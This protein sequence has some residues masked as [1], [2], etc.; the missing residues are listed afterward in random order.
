MNVLLFLRE[1][2]YLS[3]KLLKSFKIKKYII[4]KNPNFLNRIKYTFQALKIL[5]NINTIRDLLNFKK[6]KIDFGKLYMIII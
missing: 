6:Y 2:D 5:R 1:N 4:L 3:L